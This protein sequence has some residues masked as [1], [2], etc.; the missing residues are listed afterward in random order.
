MPSFLGE[1]GADLLQH[2]V[3]DLELALETWPNSAF[4]G[5]MSQEVRTV[6]HFDQLAKGVKPE[7]IAKNIV[8]GPDPEPHVKALREFI[9]AGFDHVYVHQIGPDQEGF[10][11]FYAEQVLPKLSLVA[12]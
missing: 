11:R 7:D 12:K 4:P 10:L 5:Q 9:E 3:G 2:R 6:E 8:C 1:F